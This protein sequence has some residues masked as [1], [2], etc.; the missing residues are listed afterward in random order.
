[1]RVALAL[2]LLITLAACGAGDLT[3]P[4]PGDPARLAIVAGDNQQ[5]EPGALVPDPLVVELLD[6]DGLPVA[7]RIVAFRFLDDLTGAAVDPE[8]GSTDS[9]GRVAAHARLGQQTGAQAI[10][11]F[12]TTPGEDLRV[13]FGLRAKAP[14]NGGGGGA[15]PTPTPPDDGGNPP[16][17]GGGG[18]GGQA[19]GGGQGGGGNDQ[20]GGSA[21]G[22]GGGK[23]GDDGHN[24]SDGGHG[25]KGGKGDKGDKGDDHGNG[26][27]DD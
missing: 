12:V 26:H 15:T 9:L 4:G 27:G 23:G 18:G 5:A 6:V 19:G 10:E 7:G 17:D 25:G 1:M 3:L 2:P 20:G 16:G 24:G 22:G 13:R 21:G 8:Q 11:A 14:D